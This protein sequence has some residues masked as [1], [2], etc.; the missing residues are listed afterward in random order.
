MS[1]DAPHDRSGRLRVRVVG[2]DDPHTS[3]S[4]VFGCTR[5][6]ATAA[7]SNDDYAHI[8]CPLWFKRASTVLIVL[9]RDVPV[10]ARNLPVSAF[11]LHGFVLRPQHAAHGQSI[12]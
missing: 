2:Q 9:A 7:A 10:P 12:E 6:D 8:K 4:R 5:T 3:L 1:L 11:C